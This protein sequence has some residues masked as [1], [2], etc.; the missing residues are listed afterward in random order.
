MHKLLLWSKLNI[1]QV[2]TEIELE[3]FQ[4]ATKK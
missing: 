4:E 1:K 2:Y 3:N